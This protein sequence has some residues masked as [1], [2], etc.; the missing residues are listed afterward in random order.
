MSENSR[1]KKSRREKPG[2]KHRQPKDRVLQARIPEQ[3]DEELRDQA[4]ILGISVS[5]IVRN[6]LLNTFNL[7]EGVVVDGAQI[8]R[9]FQG[10]DAG[11][12]A[13]TVATTADPAAPESPPA[14]VVG[15]QEAVLNQNSICDSCNTILPRGERGAI[16]VPTSSR[17][18][19]LCL[20]CLAQLGTGQEQTETQP[21][22]APDDSQ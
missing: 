19:I 13:D 17:P 2:R 10:R 18:I 15:W 12:P 3:L 8:A 9:A 14:T 1:S 22:T 11:A 6:V 21:N 16:G 5:T 7:V 4:E 20:E